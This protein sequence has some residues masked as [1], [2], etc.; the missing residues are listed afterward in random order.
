M[1]SRYSDVKL[2]LSKHVRPIHS[3][4]K[5]RFY[6]INFCGKSRNDR[7]LY[8]R[9]LRGGGGGGDCLL[10]FETSYEKKNVRSIHSHMKVR[11]YSPNFCGKSRNDRPLYHRNLREK[12]LFL[13]T[14]G[15]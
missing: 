4:M 6:S 7:P 1:G 14:F 13:L 8:H 9:N 11:F 2:F 10:T 12:L 15:T 5:V 3:H